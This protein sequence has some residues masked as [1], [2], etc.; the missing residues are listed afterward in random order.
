MNPFDAYM[1][2]LALKKHFTTKTYDYVKYHGKIKLNI[3]NFEKR[4]D[5]FHFAKLAKMKDPF[6][7]LLSNMI[8]DP[9]KWITDFLTVDGE[10]NYIS[11]Q[12]RN[13]SLS[14]IF[15]QELDHLDDDFKANFTVEEQYPKLYTLFLQKEISIETLIILNKMFNFFETWDK[16]IKERVLWPNK[17]LIIDKYSVFVNIDYNKYKKTVIQR[18]T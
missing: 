4:K 3:S 9:S 5:K 7:F 1:M 11:W 8:E 6:H 15:Q 18:F 13:Q 17:K 10:N 2:Y 12:K 16:Q 14:Y